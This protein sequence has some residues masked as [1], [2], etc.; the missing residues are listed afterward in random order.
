[1]RVEV[2][3]TRVRPRDF[4]MRKEDAGRRGSEVEG[5]CPT[6]KFFWFLCERDVEAKVFFSD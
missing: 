1:M 2:K 6:R 3:T 4:H 5:S